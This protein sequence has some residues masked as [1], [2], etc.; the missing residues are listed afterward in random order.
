MTICKLLIFLT[1]AIALVSLP[2]IFLQMLAASAVDAGGNSLMTV[3][4]PENIH[5]H[6]HYTH[7]LI[8]LHTHKHTN[9]HL[10][11]SQS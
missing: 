7:I 8:H 2:V 9:G 10:S 1:L 11:N 3:F 4:N 5:I 6:M